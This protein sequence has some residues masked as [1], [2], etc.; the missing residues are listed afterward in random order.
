MTPRWLY[1]PAAA[2]LAFLTLPLLG[3]P[4]R[5]AWA[6]L[7]A[8]L[9]T[10]AALDALGLSLVTC[11][12]ATVVSV[13]LGLPLA[14]LLARSDGPLAGV[15]RTLVTLPMV[16]PPVVA[17]LALLITFGRRGTVGAPLSALG[18]EIGFTTLAVVLA[19]V[20]VAMPYLVTSVEGAVRTAG[21]ARERI[22][23]SLGASPT[24]TLLHVTVPVTAPA[25]ATGTALTFARALGEFGAT[26]TFAGALQ[27][28]TRTLPLEIYQVREL[29]TASA[30]ALSLVL[31]AVAAVTVAL[32]AWL[33]R[34]TPRR[35]VA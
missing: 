3:I 6:D 4:L 14:L 21:F 2:A 28:V 33:S 9:T 18:I 10:P 13:L 23:A 16:L 31:V 19:Q 29:D 22:A 7:P 24:H 30:L 34:R 32:T 20:F 17:G 5:V 1:L 8:L 11:L 15:V 25:L 27:G 35:G 12:A 26:I